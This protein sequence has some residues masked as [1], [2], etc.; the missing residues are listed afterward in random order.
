VTLSKRR[1]GLES[2]VEV[3][4]E[5]QQMEKDPNDEKPGGR[6]GRRGLAVTQSEE[7]GRWPYGEVFF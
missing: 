3:Q 4:G 1:G 5:S 7:K 6:G 2:S